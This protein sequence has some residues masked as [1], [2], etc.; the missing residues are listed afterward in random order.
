MRQV[1]PDLH[2][3]PSD[4]AGT[5]SMKKPAA[6]G[7]KNPGARHHVTAPATAGLSLLAIQ[8]RQEAAR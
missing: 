4:A 2:P 7:K 5:I 6:R 3:V 8:S 1:H